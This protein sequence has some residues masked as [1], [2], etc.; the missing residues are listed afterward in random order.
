MSTRHEITAL[1]Y[2]KRGQLISVGKNSYTKTHPLQGKLA[3]RTKRPNRIYIHAELDAL[4]KARGRKVYKLVILRFK[5]DGS[6]GLAKPCE[7]CQKAIKL[8]GV[9]EVDFTKG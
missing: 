1:A 8:F 7:C 2:N 3:K 6:P 4:I 9:K 5:A